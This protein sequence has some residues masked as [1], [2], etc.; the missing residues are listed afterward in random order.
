M[1]YR[2]TYA[3]SCAGAGGDMSGAKLAGAKVAF[4]WDHD[5]IPLKSLKKNYLEID[6]YCLEAK[7]TP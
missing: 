5:P 4:T 7:Y 2:F 6:V 1:R 3:S